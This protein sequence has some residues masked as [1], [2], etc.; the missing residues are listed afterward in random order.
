VFRT[1]WDSV[2][3]STLVTEEYLAKAEADATELLKILDEAEDPPKG[4]PRDLRRRAYS[5]WH[6]SYTELYEVGRYLLRHDPDATQKFPGISPE[7][8]EGGDEE[9]EEQAGA[10]QQPPPAQSGSP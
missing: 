6:R 8:G 2:K 9:E 1:N 7:R 5:V 10:T 3:D 4:S